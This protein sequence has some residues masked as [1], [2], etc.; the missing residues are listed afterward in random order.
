M[1]QFNVIIVG[2]G[3]SGPLLASG[4]L[5]AG[6]KV[7]VYE[8]MAADAKRDGYQ[9]RVAQP[10]MDAF[11]LNLTPEQNQRIRASLGHFD[12]NEETTPI[13]YNH[14]LKPLLE[15]GRISE[16]YHGSAPMDRVVLRDIIIEKPVE[17]G[18]VHFGTSF[19]GYDIISERGRE[20]VRVSFDD[21]TSADCDLLIGADGSHSKVNKYLGLNNIQD[22]PVINFITKTHLSKDKLAA[23]PTAARHS[24]MLAFSHRKTYFC[25]AYIPSRQQKDVAKGDDGSSTR[26]SDY[27]ENMA[28]FTFSLQMQKDDC[29]KDIKNW[30]KDATWKFLE[31]SLSDWDD[32]FRQVIQV[33]KSEQVYVFE[34]RATRRPALDWRSKVRTAANPNLGHPRVWLMGDAM[35]VMLPNRG[36]GG[37][38]AMLDTTVIL[39]LIQRLDKVMT[40]DGVLETEV[41]AAACE[42]YER[43]MIPRTFYWVETSGGTKPV[44]FDTN[45]LFGRF[46]AWY[47]KLSL[48]I[49][50]VK[51]SILNLFSLK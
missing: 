34:P 30:D 16:Q 8:R 23:L 20:R 38:Q 11:H 32:A 17:S 19:S 5:H 18:I 10:S 35:H 49:R 39:P 42:E 51:H 22:I 47:M 14:E 46:V 21:G 25:V 36:M 40:T 4:L 37:N 3:L 6:V 31:E 13:W 29:P 50:D 1:P 26:A 12:A 15:M 28:T 2:C 44:P 9:I 41:V 48:D 33:I 45:T 24:P 43:E 7:D 27:D